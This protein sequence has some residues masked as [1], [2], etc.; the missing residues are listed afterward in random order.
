MLRV[1]IPVLMMGGF[2]MPLAQA[3]DCNNLV[4]EDPSYVKKKRRTTNKYRWR[5]GGDMSFTLKGGCESMT[6]HYIQET[7]GRA[8]R[9]ERSILDLDMK[10]GIRKGGNPWDRSD[11]MFFGWKIHGFN[12]SGSSVK[13]EHPYKEW[14]FFD[15][16]YTYGIDLGPFDVGAKVGIAGSAAILHEVEYAPDDAEFSLSFL[17][18]VDINGYAKVG[19]DIII[20]EVWIGGKL[21]FVKWE[22]VAQ[23]YV[24]YTTDD[25]TGAQKVE[26]GVTVDNKISLLSGKL[27]A[28]AEIGPVEYEHKFIEWWGFKSKT[29]IWNSQDGFVIRDAFTRQKVPQV[30]MPGMPAPPKV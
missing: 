16:S 23:A 21:S 20:A 25:E 12:K 3:E 30:L 7:E 2:L 27:Y 22:L 11:A 15:V 5:G 24:A 26:Q 18:E 14:D 8:A 19:A 10:G 29:P 9:L 1:L 4:N 17:P 28:K 13:A 6:Y